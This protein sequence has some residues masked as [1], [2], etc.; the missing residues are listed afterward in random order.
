MVKNSSDLSIATVDAQQ[1][2][3]IIDE[4]LFSSEDPLSG[5]PINQKEESF[6]S[7]IGKNN[8]FFNARVDRVLENLNFVL[9][10][11]FAVVLFVYVV[12]TVLD[13]RL[14]KPLLVWVSV[15]L[16]ITTIRYA[17]LRQLRKSRETEVSYDFR[18]QF[19]ILGT[20]SA[21]IGWGLMPFTVAPDST[22]TLTILATLWMAGMLTGA[23][24]TLSVM[25]MV[26]AAFVIPASIT[27]IISV[28]L[29]FEDNSFELIMSFLVF[30]CF[31]VPIALHIHSDT[32]KHIL[33]V[34][35]N[36]RMQM[37]LAA[38][39]KR[40]LEQEE[41]LLAQRSREAIL[42]A[43]KARA[44]AKLQ[45]AAEDRNLLLN[46]LQE[47][48]FG[49]SD[50]GAITFINKS[51]LDMLDYEE[52]EVIGMSALLLLNPKEESSN[53]DPITQTYT[54]GT[55][56]ELI[57][58]VFRKK[59]SDSL[60]VRYSAEPVI[61]RNN[62]VGAVV[63]FIDLSKQQEMETRLM[64][65]Q[66]ME[67]IGRLTG[68]VAHDFN[69]LLTVILGNLQFLERRFADNQDALDLI[70]KILGA[71]QSGAELNNRL[72][73]FSREQSLRTANVNIGDM[74]QGMNEFFARMLGE[75]IKLICEPC[76]QE[77]IA[78][79]DSAQ[80]ENAILNLCINA[81][82]A[83]PKGG[84]VTLSARRCRRPSS[85]PADKN[86]ENSDSFIELSIRDNGTGM[87]KGVRDKIF[88]P[89]FTTKSKGRG[90]GLGL[91]TVY[92]F[93]T[94][95]GGSLTV[96]S[97][98]GKGTHFK[99]YLPAGRTDLE[100]KLRENT[101]PLSSKSHSGI[102]LVVEDNDSVR[103]VAVQMLRRVGYRVIEAT[104]AALGLMKFDAHPEIDFVFSDIIMP[105]GIN[106]IAMAEKMLAMRPQ[107]P[108]LL[109]TGYIERE[110]RLKLEQHPSIRSI[111]K[112]YNT[113]EI[114]HII[115]S[116]LDEARATLGTQSM[117]D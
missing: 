33:A 53:N 44:D 94:Q 64:Q 8:A 52:D 11:D 57:G 115:A 45:T 58:S 76:E 3:R 93:I 16:A 107:T 14:N 74:L 68:G 12:S 34:L 95:S 79:T 38:E 5:N 85:L 87:P 27:F 47:G 113:N 101:V 104:D 6:S 110:L 62:V 114:P 31:I 89:F 99:L 9:T 73:S 91:S 20:F 46:A 30:I 49:I 17:I 42:E 88:E 86:S 22:P 67:A 55:P 24:V 80:L 36:Q 18:Y 2:P 83:M 69:N 82:D 97:A 39:A 61:E 25:R 54:E 50:V 65:S 1:T 77:C 41:K 19:L 10:G 37:E 105:G 103:D 35:E 78:A 116:M 32:G 71:A 48:I 43:Q 84:T 100:T 59:S 7:Q 63:S 51:A 117:H 29:H 28:F 40:L 26:F 70:K 60:P 81:K 108:I 92:G 90:T 56:A 21:G 66:K 4:D 96:D 23:A 111:A 15:L 98:P 106:G 112:P 13:S 75:N 72:L 102:I 109:A